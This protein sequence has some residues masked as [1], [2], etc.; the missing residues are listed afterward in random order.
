MRI[1][2]ILYIWDILGQNQSHVAKYKMAEIY[3]LTENVKICPFFVLSKYL[4]K[5]LS[6]KLIFTLSV[7]VFMHILAFEELHLYLI[8][9]IFFF[10]K[11]IF[12]IILEF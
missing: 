9:H 4:C 6:F 10:F 1:H 2:I 12:L 7:S 8:K 3:I 5:F 11:D